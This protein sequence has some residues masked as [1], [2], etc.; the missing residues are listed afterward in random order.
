MEPGPGTGPRAGTEQWE[1][2]GPNPSELRCNVKASTHYS[3]T[4]LFPVP[5]P[6]PGSVQCEYTIK[7][8]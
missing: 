8:E 2:I 6:C 3:T 7:L 1:T 4:H 5:C